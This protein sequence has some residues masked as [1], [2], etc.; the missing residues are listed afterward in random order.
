MQ[1]RP[2]ILSALAGAV[3]ALPVLADTWPS[4][5]IRLVVPFAPGGATDVVARII[6]QKLA[7]GLGQPV[8]IDNKAG[9]NGIVGTDVVAKAAPD[10]YTLLL[11][12]ASAQTLTPALYKLPFDPLKDLAPIS[13]VA[14]LGGVMVVHPSVPAKTMQEF[15]ALVRSKPG[16]YDFAAGTSLIQLIGENFKKATGA[17][18]VPIPYKGTGPQLAA[19]L[20]GEVAMTIDPFTAVSHIKA[21]RLRALAVLLPKRSPLLPDVPTMIEV[22]VQGVELNSWAGL[23]APTG[24]PKPV[25]ARLHEEIR[26]IVAMPDVKERLASLNYEPVGNTPE[27]FAALMVTETAQWAKVVKETNFKIE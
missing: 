17:Y 9:A 1:R 11:T 22:G 8:V 26:K 5:P 24:T 27:Q 14:N 12:V 20:A 23:L 25:I 10:G 15:I 2:L 6:S 3:T 13:I 19:V 7:D 18:I 21:G 16:K 4:K